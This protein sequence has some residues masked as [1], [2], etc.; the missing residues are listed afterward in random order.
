MHEL[1]V[2]DRDGR[3]RFGVHDLRTIS[4][5]QLLESARRGVIDG[6]PLRPYLIV[7]IGYGDAPPIDWPTFKAAWDV[8]YDVVQIVADVGGAAAI[9]KSRGTRC[10]IG[11]SAARKASKLIGTSGRRCLSDRIN[12]PRFSGRGPGPPRS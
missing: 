4:V 3:L 7:E 10:A 9:L 12:S 6:D 5:E 1:T 2:V 8:A 11:S